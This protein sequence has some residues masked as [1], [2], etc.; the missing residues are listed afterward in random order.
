MQVGLYDV[1]SV[2][3]DTAFDLNVTQDGYYPC[4]IVWFREAPLANNH[5]TAGFELYTITSS[6][7]KILVNDTNTPGAVLAFQ[8]S[9]A[10][11]APYV[12]Y[13]GPAAFVS[14]YRGNDFG[15]P[16]VQVQIHDGTSAAVDPAS[17]KMSIDG[18]LVSA[19]VTNRSA[20]TTVT[21]LASGTQLPR[22]VHTGQVS[23]TVGGTNTTKTWQFDRLLARDERCRLLRGL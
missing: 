4:R 16:R 8:S 21:Y 22:T 13:A 2:P 11:V 7:Q 23:F 14:S 10:P 15:L 5:G 1:R 20:L 12:Q 18:S 3:W 9:S 6:G 17:V 19:A